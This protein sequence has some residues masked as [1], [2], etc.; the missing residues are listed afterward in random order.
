MRPSRKTTIR[1]ENHDIRNEAFW[2]K[3]SEIFQ[4]TREMIVEWAKEAGMD[5]NGQATKTRLDINAKRQL[6]DNHPLTRAGK[7]YANAASDWFR[8]FDQ[9]IRS[10]A[11][12]RNSWRMRAK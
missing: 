12:L 7:K 3:L 4:E 9:M 2:Q 10:L 11:R 5:L 1:P 8:E 6:V